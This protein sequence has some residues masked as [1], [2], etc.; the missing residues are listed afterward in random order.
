LA[1]QAG[2]YVIVS[3]QGSTADTALTSRREAMRGALAGAKNA[4]ALAVDFYDRTRIATWVRA[5]NGLIPWVRA[6]AGRP[7]RG[8]Q[9]YGAWAPESDNIPYL[10]DDALR[11]RRANSEAEK[12]VPAL[13]GITELRTKLRAPRHV[14]RLV[15]LSGVG[16]T[17]LVQALFEQ[18]VGAECLDPSLAMYTNMADGP[19]PPPIGMA[20][21]LVARQARI[22][23]V[24]DNCPSD[25]HHR[26][27]EVCR[28]TNSLLSLLTIEYDIQDDTPEGTDVFKLE[29]SSADLIERLL[30]R[31]FA[32]ISEIDAKSIASFSGGNARVAIALAS[33]V[34]KHDTLAGLT[35]EALFRRL[36]RQGQGNDEQLYLDAQ[37][38]ALLYSFH[39]EDTSVTGELARL[40]TLIGRSPQELYRSVAELRRRDLA[41]ARSAWR[42]VLPHAIANRLATVALQ[43][44]PF[45]EIERQLFAD[46][47]SRML[48]SFSRR[49]GYLHRSAE[50]QRIVAGW[51]AA[52]GLLARIDQLNELGQAMLRNIAPVAPEATVTALERAIMGAKGSDVLQGCRQH[53]NLLRALAYDAP[54]FDRCVELLVRLESSGPV[55]RN[56]PG[57]EMFS[58]L[59]H[60]ILSG[61]HARVEQRADRLRALLTSGDERR[62]TLGIAGL[63]AMLTTRHMT[64]TAEFDFGARPRDFGYWPST[65]DEV[66]HWFAVA[67]QSAE[68]AACDHPPT[69]TAARDVLAE[70]FGDLWFGS[71]N[72][73]EFARIVRRLHSLEPWPEGWL[74]IRDILDS[75]GN[76]MPTDSRTA[77]TALEKDLRPADLLQQ[78]RM[79]ARTEH[80][81]G[82]DLEDVQ[83]STENAGEKMAKTEELTRNLGRMLATDSTVRKEVVPELLVSNAHLWPLG[84]G[85]AIQ[86]AQ[87]EELWQELVDAFANIE[88]AARRAPLLRG[89]LSTLRSRD[90]ALTDKLLDEAIEHQ[91][92]GPWFPFLQTAVELRERDVQRLKQ[93]LASGKTAAAAYNALRYGRAT[94][95]VR[96]DDLRDVLLAIA[97]MQDGYAVSLEILYMRLHNDVQHEG[98]VAP[99]LMEAGR[100]LLARVPFSGKDE[101]MD[102]R[103]GD[104]VRH[105]LGGTEGEA[106]TK[107]LCARLKHAIGTYETNI[108]Y[109]DDLLISLFAVQPI[110][111]LDG[112]FG[113]TPEELN[114]GIRVLGDGLLRLQPLAT[115]PDQ[116]V[117]AWCDQDPQARYPALAKVIPF[118]TRAKEPPR[119]TSIALEFLEKAPDPNA[120]LRQFTARF[121]TKGVWTNTFGPYL[122]SMASLFEQL[123]RYPH[124]KDTIA[125][126]KQT[127]ADWIDDAK[128][129]SSVWQEHQDERFE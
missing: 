38:C 93:A 54:L 129:R 99:A 104:I 71:N 108:I 14:I 3:S 75:H 36:F 87:P 89:F 86:A 118:F 77:L 17:R 5:H 31:R 125:E 40:G 96:P 64:S 79:I 95:P 55:D 100:E 2:A 81:W 68:A 30:R 85:L 116:D 103:M 112:I 90:P 101:H 111:A 1:D 43:N 46:E 106:L 57:V 61:T 70:K 15:G 84:E 124:L 94:A 69:K 126:Q 110:A 97:A 23:L 26:L 105:C 18:Q 53:A 122:E 92:L 73:N 115:V 6:L 58:S 7:L 119:W 50:A 10:Q 49:L 98:T 114:Q 66:Q 20:A 29:P 32:A 44:I 76:G 4:D 35:D 113:D 9:S 60:V 127:I 51:L 72:R 120:I 27:A 128:K 39:S 62:R 82:V 107:E 28:Q 80:H 74:A 59:F 65:N 48:R 33:T 13:Q 88:P 34:G 41:Q 8:W 78:V 83:E 109:H 123:D 16:K 56:A 47:S 45:Q 121:A 67:L 52:D 21:E 11:L 102:R 19:E 22:I 12:G 117:L 63:R 37:V 25:L 91:T 24:V 42:A